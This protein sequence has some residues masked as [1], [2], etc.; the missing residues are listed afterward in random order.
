GLGAAASG[1]A[2]AARNPASAVLKGPP[3]SLRHRS[4]NPQQPNWSA[5][6][7]D[8]TS[9]IPYRHSTWLHIRL[10]FRSLAIASRRVP[11]GELRSCRAV[12]RLTGVAYFALIRAGS[13]GRQGT[14]ASGAAPTVV[15]GSVSSQTYASKSITSRT[16]ARPACAGSWH[17]EVP[18]RRPLC[19]R[20]RGPAPRYRPRSERTP[21]AGVRRFPAFAGRR[22]PPDSRDTARPGGA[23]SVQCNS[24]H[25]DVTEKPR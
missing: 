16:A 14:S 8:A 24:K 10:R 13:S 21:G 25:G 9:P 23:P 15:T 22:L 5:N 2:T 4:R 1:P 19:A 11:A 7:A 12:Q 17:R 3:V 18:R 20:G 6:T